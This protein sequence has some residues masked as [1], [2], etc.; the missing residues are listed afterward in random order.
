MAASENTKSQL[1]AGSP[2]EV[3]SGSVTFQVGQQAAAKRDQPPPAAGSPL[4]D[5]LASLHQAST[6]AEDAAQGVTVAGTE[7]P[8]KGDPLWSRGVAITMGWS[9][10]LFTVIMLALAT[11]LLWR[12]NMNG[13]QIVRLFLL[14]LIISM[15]AFLVVVGY[16]DK[17]LMPIIGLFGAIAGYLLGRD[18][19]A[20]PP[21]PSSAPANP[22]PAKDE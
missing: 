11:A 17:Q 20:Q 12:R 21:S 9:L 22:T 14:V 15:S 4:T 1:G 13:V 19:P 5:G 3:A 10:L 7:Q 18:P 8:I 2:T 6:G 16:T